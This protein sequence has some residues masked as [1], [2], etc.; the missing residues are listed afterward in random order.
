VLLT[1]EH[2]FFLNHLVHRLYT[3]F[4]SRRRSVYAQSNYQSSFTVICILC[5]IGAFQYYCILYF[6][7][8]HVSMFIMLIVLKVCLQ[9]V[10]VSHF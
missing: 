2:N 9:L 4:S 10:S 7:Y 3:F 8:L 1:R 5:V 6:V